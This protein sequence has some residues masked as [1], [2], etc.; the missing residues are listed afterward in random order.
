LDNS[1]FLLIA[2]PNF[3]NQFC[4]N[5]LKSLT[6]GFIGLPV[7]SLVIDDSSN[8]E[9]SLIDSNNRNTVIITLIQGES[10]ESRCLIAANSKGMPCFV[11]IMKG[12]RSD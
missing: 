2:L 5:D 1:S 4:K 6:I 10:P 8:F 3:L 7:Y 12:L 9:G 11:V